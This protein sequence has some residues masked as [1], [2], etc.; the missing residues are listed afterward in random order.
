MRSERGA[1]EVDVGCYGRWQRRI[2]RSHVV[3]ILRETHG[4]AIIIIADEEQ[5]AKEQAPECTEVVVRLHPEKPPPANISAL[6]LPWKIGKKS[7]DP[8]KCEPVSIV[9]TP[10]SAVSVFRRA[11]PRGMSMVKK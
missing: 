10:A 6:A 4:A 8:E 3:E 1:G 2:K 5:P 7:P 11:A 9:T